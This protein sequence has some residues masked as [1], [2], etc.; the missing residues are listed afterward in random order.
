[1]KNNKRQLFLISIFSLL[2]FNLP[3]LDFNFRPRV[4]ACFPSEVASE[5]GNVMYGMGGGGDLGFE[6]DLSSVLSNPLGIGYTLGVEGG[7]LFSG[8]QTDV[9]KSV[10][11]YSLGGGIGLYFFPLS[12]IFTRVDGAI[13][14][15]IPSLDGKTGY[16]DLFWRGGGEI[17]FRFTP[18]FTIAANAGWRQF[19][20]D[21]GVF[22]S[23]IYAGVTA[24][25]GFQ[26]GKD[27]SREALG[28]VFD[29]DEGVYPAFMQLYQRNA[30][31]WL[32][33]RN[34]ENAEI[35]DV[36]VSFRAP[37]YTASEFPC[38][39][40]SFIARGSSAELPLLA[41]FSTEVLRF[42]D[43]GR[44]L[45]EVVIRYRFL[46]K[47]REEVR[48]VILAA[49]NRNMV[50]EGDAAALAAFISPTSPEVLNYTKNIAELA[51]N[52]RRTGHNQNF[53]YAIWLLEGLRSGGIILS[54]AYADKAEAQFPAET[55]SFRSGS[56]RDIALLFAGGLESVGIPAAFVQIEN[57]FL[58]AVSLN[59]NQSA[60]ETLF[61]GSGKILIIND[62]V[63]LPLS[64]SA[65]NEGFTTAWTRGVKALDDNFKAGKAADF[66]MVEEAWASYPPAPLPEQG[67]RAV[68]TDNAAAAREVNRAMQQYIAQE[69]QPV[70]NQVQA[71]VN[72]SPTAALYNRLGILLVR[73]GRAADGK[74]NYERAA[75]MGF[76]PAMTNRGN[77]ALIERDFAAAERWFRQALAKDS[78]NSAAIRGLEQAMEKR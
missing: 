14:M 6:V 60:A 70:L 15:Y 78:E 52:D 2:I 74:V 50:T 75:G 39:V 27:A 4:F 16:M 54:G 17:G 55:L 22:N 25:L 44:I 65:F 9:E 68:R 72:A 53:Q 1:M 46:G 10:A 62:R 57:D 26:T 18:G 19:L 58:V 40:R 47:E 13:G 42:T 59:V 21:S 64:M 41:D 28:V 43:K 69:I 8:I 23:G 34:N 11:I 20:I 66:V 71:Q 63:W 48:S 5:K 77:L 38:G 61:N 67:G 24:Q 36:R 7:M 73:A 76:V 32:V 56:A 31:G 3:A 49:N 30:A 29:Q 33:I 45:G 51:R 35:R 37:P 12:R